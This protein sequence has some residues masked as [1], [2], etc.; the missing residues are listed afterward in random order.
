MTFRIFLGVKIQQ[1]F[2]N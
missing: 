1:S 2:R